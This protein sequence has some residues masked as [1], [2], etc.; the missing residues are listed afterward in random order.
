MDSQVKDAIATYQAAQIKFDRA[1]TKCQAS[2]EA[3]GWQWVKKDISEYGE[4]RRYQEWL[5]SPEMYAS[6]Q[7]SHYESPPEMMLEPD[8]EAWNELVDFITF[9]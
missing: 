4:G 2:L 3:C 1:V 7:L 6:L 5:V 9:Y 8:Y